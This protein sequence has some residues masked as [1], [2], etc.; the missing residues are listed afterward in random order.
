MDF[1]SPVPRLPPFASRLPVQ[2]LDDD[3]SSPWAC[4]PCICEPAFSSGSAR[5]A[6]LS[7]PADPASGFHR[8]HAHRARSLFTRPCRSFWSAFDERIRDPMSPTDFCNNVTTCGQPN[9]GSP[10]LAG[11]EAMT[12]FRFCRA[13]GPSCEGRDTGQAALRPSRNAPCWF[14]P[15]T[16]FAQR[17]YV[18]RRLL[19]EVDVHGSKDQ[20][21]DASLRAESVRSRYE[22]LTL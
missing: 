10:I 22:V 8:R 14:L 13:S 21:K 2:P 7:S 4:L 11:T 3:L 20:A 15:V 12:S 1:V 6:T 5:P 18:S 16:R 17:R 19:A 9:P